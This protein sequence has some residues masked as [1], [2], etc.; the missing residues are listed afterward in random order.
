MYICSTMGVL[1]KTEWTEKKIQDV[2]R[3]YFL[4]PSTKKYDIA[5]LFIYGWESDYLIITQSMLAY[6]IEIKV[7]RADFKNDLKKKTDKHLLLEGGGKLGRFNK[8]S[9]MPNYFYYAVPDGLIQPEEVPEYAG[10][11]YVKVYGVTIVKEAKK[12]TDEKFDP[13]KMKLT[14]K[15]Y[16]NMWNWKD[17]FEK[18]RDVEAD[19]KWYKKQIRGFNETFNTYE[20]LLGSK[21]WEISD[22]QDKIKKL[23]DEIERRDSRDG[24]GTVLAQ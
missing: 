17:K 6:E 18:F 10:L 5:N 24:E 16:Y 14:D 1:K 15:F 11:I 21:E 20:E 12:L 4:S 7:S 2:L 3:M 8:E 19:I 9:G 13:E 22:L 23:E